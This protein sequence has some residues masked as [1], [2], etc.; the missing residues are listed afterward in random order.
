MSDPLAIYLQDHLAGAELAIDMLHALSAQDQTSTLGMF[1]AGLVGDIEQDRATLRQIAERVGDGGSTLKD[2]TAWI[3]EK[4]TRLKL[5]S[6][7]SGALGTLETL[8]T[9]SLGILGKAKLWRALAEIAASEDPRL[10]GVN[11]DQLVDRA[12]A[13]HEQVEARRLQAARAALRAA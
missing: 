5:N 9:L 8:E 1:A 10:Q 13:Q 6:R 11:F 12:L 7:V 2:A 3:G 4:L